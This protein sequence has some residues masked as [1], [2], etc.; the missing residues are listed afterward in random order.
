MNI[1]TRLA[2]LTI[3][4]LG[5]P[6]A[7][8]ESAARLHVAHDGAN[9]SA[10]NTVTVS[11]SNP[12]DHDVFVY[13]YQ[14]AFAK[15][16]GRMTGDW[17]DVEDEFGNSIRYK[18]RFVV[19]GA[20]TP[21]AFTRIPPGSSVTTAI[22]LSREYQLPE[23]G[24]VFVSTKVALYENIPSILA[25]G[26]VEDVPHKLITSD[27]TSFFVA[28]SA[29]Q[30]SKA[31]SVT[32]CT[33]EQKDATQR[34]IASAQSATE[35]ATRFLSGLYYGEAP[36]PENP[37][38]PFHMTP[39]HR[40]QNWFGVWDDAAP[41][42]PPESLPTDNYRVDLTVNAAYIR[43]FLGRTET[44]CDQ[45]GGYDPSTRAWA[46]GILIHLCPANFSD[47][48]TGGIISQA[49]T[50]A[51]EVSHQNDEIASGTVDLPGVTNRASAHALPRPSAVTSAANYEYFITNTPL[52][53]E[54]QP[55]EPGTGP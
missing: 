50:I 7:A 36:T 38:P 32:A 16:D 51:H 39:H 17:F 11:L 3:L 5:G 12:S 6:A 30:P 35:E 24:R 2:A 29:N 13:A 20:P 26:E 18:G 19:S 27:S 9:S 34:A 47:P 45:C 44:V 40:Y 21:S 49:G 31:S 48:I 43:L 42:Y 10:P 25:N 14:T 54:E 23:T 4:S 55:S 53:R 22:D 8:T 28:P 33:P 46:E 37:F 1:G 15:P 52:G 41:Q